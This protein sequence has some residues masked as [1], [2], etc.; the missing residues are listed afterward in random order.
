MDFESLF[1]G[2][3]REPCGAGAPGGGGEEP[4]VGEHPSGRP[5]EVIQPTEAPHNSCPF[6]FVCKAMHQL[7]GSDE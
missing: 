5:H 4:D 1:A 6:L 3:V 7:Y 2:G